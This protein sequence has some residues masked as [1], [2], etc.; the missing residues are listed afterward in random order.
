MFAQCGWKLAPPGPLSSCHGSCKRS[1]FRALAARKLVLQRV[2]CHTVVLKSDD[3][4]CRMHKCNNT[5]SRYKS[6]PVV[7]GPHVL[8]F[9]IG[10]HLAE[11]GLKLKRGRLCKRSR[12]GSK[13]SPSNKGSPVSVVS[14]AY[15][16]GHRYA[17][18]G[19]Q[20]EAREHGR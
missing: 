5:P 17:L 18:H 8:C 1:G 13:L 9:A 4:A 16:Q 14:V 15:R 2:A 20:Q 19:R 10:S 12:S 3:F 11:V 6:C 7:E